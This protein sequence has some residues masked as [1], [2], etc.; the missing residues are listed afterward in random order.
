[1]DAQARIESAKRAAARLAVDTH[2]KSGMVVGV[3]SG[4]TVVYA[5]E[6]LGER[7]RE[8]GLQLICLPTSFQ[9]LQLIHDNNLPL[10]DLSRCPQLDVAIDGADEV[11]ANMN[12]I[13]GGGAAHTQEK[14]IAYNS[15]LFVI[16]ADY[17]KRS[18]ILGTNWTSGVPIE[19]M[20]MAYVC[21]QR[22]CAEL[23]GDAKL[24]MAPA[25]KA[26]PVV[27]DNGNF[28]LDAVFGQ[29]ADPEGLEAAINAIPGVIACGL[30]VNMAHFAYFGEEDGSVT[31]ANRLE[32]DV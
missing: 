27:T 22:K 2:V 8:E 21:V 15:K 13:K 17:R 25:G 14:I 7:A 1:M 32:L 11:D 29:I 4:S 23:G 20:P 26:G 9:A 5:A 12:C 6:R 30:F 31:S 10:G 18:V 19:V 24:R 28:V 3:G 16:V